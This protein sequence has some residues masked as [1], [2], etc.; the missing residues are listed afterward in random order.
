[1][2]CVYTKHGFEFREIQSA[3]GRLRMTFVPALGGL[4]VS[5]RHDEK[6]LLWLH[7]KFWQGE[8]AC[9]YGGWPFLFPICGRLERDGIAGGYL[10]R[11]DRYMMPIHGLTCRYPWRVDHHDAQS[12]GLCSPTRN[13]PGWNIRFPLRWR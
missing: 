11:G 1:M 13:K 6:E 4:G 8:G 5:L 7:E 9:R 10:Y 12:S 2:S 3:G